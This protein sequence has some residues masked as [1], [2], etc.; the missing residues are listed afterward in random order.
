MSPAAQLGEVDFS[1][2]KRPPRP[3][4]KS[5]GRFQKATQPDAD[6]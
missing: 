4:S 3:R 6:D 2:E 1:E 5:T